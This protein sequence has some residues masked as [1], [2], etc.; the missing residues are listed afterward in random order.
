[1]RDIKVTQ[2]FTENKR[3]LNLF[4][5]EAT[6]YQPLTPAQEQTA[7]KEELIK[8]NMLFVVSVAKYYHVKNIDIMDL[9]SE[10]MIG[11]DIAADR[12]DKTKGFKFISYAVI[13]IRQKMIEY[14][15][16]HSDTVYLPRKHKEMYSKINRHLDKKNDATDDELAEVI[17]DHGDF[18]VK[19]YKQGHSIESMDSHYD[20]L[21]DD[22]QKQYA[23]DESA[24]VL[25]DDYDRKQIVKKIYN[26]L[27]DREAFIIQ[28]LYIEGVSLNYVGDK[29][30]LTHERI[31][32]IRNF[33]LK[34]IRHRIGELS[35]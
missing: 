34:K 2:R 30:N 16:L 24:E 9:I 13:W 6:K 26:L 5:A 7:T 32:Q 35:L 31:R 27:D 14:L 12:F 29:L 10:G 11:L 33:A 8:H 3:T 21:D 1:M 4:L 18:Y 15:N 17:G 20:W 25:S 22:F 28:K 19:S 23:S